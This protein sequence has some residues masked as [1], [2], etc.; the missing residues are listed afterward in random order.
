[1]SVCGRVCSDHRMVACSREPGHGGWW[2]EGRHPIMGRTYT[3]ASP[4]QDAVLT[5][6]G[7]LL[8][9]H[10]HVPERELIVVLCCSTAALTALLCVT[11]LAGAS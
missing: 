5:E 10:E 9:P 7:K 1:M 8:D 2:C 4:E 3:W 6:W 11:A